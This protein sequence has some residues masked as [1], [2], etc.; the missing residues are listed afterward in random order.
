MVQAMERDDLPNH[1]RER[2]EVIGQSGET[3]LTILN[4]ILDLS[5]IEAGKL[6][7]ESSDFDIEALAL[8][9][10]KTF[11]PIALGKGL[12]FRLR[13]DSGAC[14]VYRG[15]AVRV[16]Q[17]LYNLISNALKFTS[18][19]SVDV[20]VGPADEGL[21]FSVADTG[22]GMSPDRIERLFERFVQADS[23]TTRQFG[24]T[25]LGLPICRELC[26]AMGG[27]ITA[28][29]EVGVGSRFNV[30]LPLQRARQAPSAQDAVIVEP[31]ALDERPLRI[32]AAEDN[33]VNQLVL[34]T[35][36]G[37]AGLDP[38]VVANGREAVSAWENGDW[39]LILMDVQMPVLDGVMATREIRRLEAASNR[40]PTPILA[41]S[42]NAMT[43]QLEA[44]RAAGM[45]G[46]IAKPIEVRQLFEAVALA[47]QPQA[48][49]PADANEAS[50]A[51]ALSN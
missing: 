38:V 12:A 13:M 9:A 24:G 49:A 45:N 25:G 41:L 2:L 5:K 39:D 51:A 36:L 40:L 29:S 34:R 16:R 23:S 22:I 44:Y 43:H 37:Q 18:E 6:E 8:A 46:F 17:I 50:A 28:E 14:G 27:E 33:A 11:E 26:L 21:S 31:R 15:D 35:L 30:F 4:D 10:Q 19:G 47:T 42:A 3:L 1:Q 20:S 48:S 7:L 32:L